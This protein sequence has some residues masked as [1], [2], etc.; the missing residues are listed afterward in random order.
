MYAIFHAPKA[1]VLADTVKNGSANLSRFEGVCWKLKVANH[2]IQ[3]WL[4]IFVAETASWY[5]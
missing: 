1:L 5:P 4:S 3:L 2:G